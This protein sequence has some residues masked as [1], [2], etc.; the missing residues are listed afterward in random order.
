MKQTKMLSI[1]TAAALLTT[2]AAYLPELAQRGSIALEAFAEE[3]SSTEL[4]VGTVTGAPGERVPLTV[5]ISS[6]EA[7]IQYKYVLHYDSR[8]GIAVEADYSVSDCEYD[9]KGLLTVQGNVETQ[10]IGVG[11]LAGTSSIKEETV[12]LYFTIPGD[13]RD[14]ERFAVALEEGH[15]LMLNSMMETIENAKITGEGA[16]IAAGGSAGTTAPAETTS[17]APA[18]TTST[19]PAETTSTAPAETTSTIPAETT[20]VS[21]R[22]SLTVRAEAERALPG[23][24]V[25]VRITVKCAEGFHLAEMVFHYEGEVAFNEKGRELDAESEAEIDSLLVNR[26]TKTIVLGL[27]TETE[28][29]E[30]SAVL[31]FRIPKNAKPGD[32]IQLTLSEEQSELESTDKNKKISFEGAVPA[33]SFSAL[34]KLG[35]LNGDGLITVSDAILLARIIAEDSTVEATNEM[36]DAADFDEDGLIS[37]DDMVKLLRFI[38]GLE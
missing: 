7:L 19:A 10:Q 11:V 37:A 20:V 28:V 12:T 30:A 27:K 14:G 38:V 17:T 26:N 36:N 8:L 22:A 29:T 9:G 13:A 23:E 18:E 31:Y 33:V 6:T 24:L 15:T 16:V 2:G 1:L 32:S 5:A 4:T 3:T 34:R 35:D 25:P 21:G